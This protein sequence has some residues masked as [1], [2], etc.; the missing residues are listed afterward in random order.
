LAAGVRYSRAPAGKLLPR[1]EQGRIVGVT[2]GDGDF[3][4]RIERNFG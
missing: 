1:V 3:G 4:E 2:G